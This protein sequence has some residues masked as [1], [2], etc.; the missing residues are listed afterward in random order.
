[1]LL[2]NGFYTTLVIS[3]YILAVIYSLLKAVL[4]FFIVKLVKRK[5]VGVVM[6]IYCL[7]CLIC[8]HILRMIANY[9]AWEL[10]ITTTLMI[11]C[12][13]LCSFAWDYVD[14]G[15]DESTLSREQK[16][17]AIR[18]EATFLEFLAAA[19]GPTQCFAGPCSNFVDFKDYVY[20]RGIYG[21]LPSTFIP[22][23]KR[24]LRGWIFAIL[25]VGIH[26]LY[27]SKIIIAPDYAGK[28]YFVKVISYTTLS[29]T[30]CL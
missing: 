19:I 21:S 12:I 26:M 16:K 25:Y 13:H 23:M 24:F 30:M 17:N 4:A 5:Y 29:T 28:N 27:P 8:G 1:M 3:P 9:G 10:E 20:R 11:E 14:G 6:T 22:C 2:F 7:S 15:V 18:E